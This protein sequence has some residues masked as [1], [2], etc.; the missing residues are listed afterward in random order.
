MPARYKLIVAAF[1][2]A[3]TAGPAAAQETA[4][5]K[6]G[7]SVSEPVKAAV[8][9]ARRLRHP[10]GKEAD[11]AKD[12]AARA[13][14]ALERV[15]GD[16]PD[17][18]RA[19]FNLALARN[20]AGDYAGAKQAFEAAATLRDRLS[21]PDVTLFNSAGWAALN[22]GDY[23]AAERWLVRALADEDQASQRTR[24]AIHYNL[25]KTYFYTNRRM[26]ARHHAE[27]SSRI[28]DNREAQLLLRLIAESAS[29]LQKTGP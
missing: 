23:V 29:I 4:P 22:N 11:Q 2:L 26:Q 6:F 21:I 12:D 17:Y 14:D 20:E 5:D 1:A 24:A 28:I 19:W 16:H 25:A 8:L 13:A 27:L 15:V 10:G 18:F 9:S 3:L 7:Q